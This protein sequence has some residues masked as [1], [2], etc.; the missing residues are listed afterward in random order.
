MEMKAWNEPYG[1]WALALCWLPAGVV[2]QA[3]ARFLPQAGG[4]PEA[5]ML[6]TAAMMS[7]SSLV[8][9]APCGLPLALGCRR[10]WR[11]GRRRAAWWLGVSLGAP[12]VAASVF[13]GLLGPV[14][15]AVVALLAS[16]PVWA[17]SWW[18]A[19]RG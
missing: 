18:L 4:A 10:L 17:A 3:A 6:V 1:F 13:A 9:L 19:R 11:L 14:A 15:I 16:V 8:V 7:V 12:T 2:A 5:G